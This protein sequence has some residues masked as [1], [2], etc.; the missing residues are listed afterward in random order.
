MELLV[1]GDIVPA[2]RP[3]SLLDEAEQLMAI[4]VTCVKNAKSRRDSG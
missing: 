1:D 3:S 2:A 4:L